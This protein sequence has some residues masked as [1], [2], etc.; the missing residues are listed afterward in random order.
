[1]D[2]IRWSD[3]LLLGGVGALQLG[4]IAAGVYVV[5]SGA[6]KFAEDGGADWRYWVRSAVMLTALGLVLFGWDTWPPCESRDPVFGGCESSSDAPHIPRRISREARRTAPGQRLQGRRSARRL[7]GTALV[8]DCDVGEIG[9]SVSARWHRPD[10]GLIE[11]RLSC[12]VAQGS[13]ERQFSEDAV[14][15]LASLL[16][17]FLCCHGCSVPHSDRVDE[18]RSAILTKMHGY[19]R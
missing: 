15:R 18:I 17:E 7:F 14:P 13:D 19:V 9:R 2:G 12:G 1:M 3:A 8:M 16:C 6:A 11:A 10:P 4:V 5:Y